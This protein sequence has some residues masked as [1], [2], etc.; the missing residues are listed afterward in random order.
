V[1]GFIFG[2]LGSIFG[3]LGFSF[4]ASVA[5]LVLWFYFRRSGFVFV[6]LVSFSGVARI[7]QRAQHVDRF[8]IFF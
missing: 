8:N 5:F 2:V 4:G 6:C 1:L 3:V 7:L